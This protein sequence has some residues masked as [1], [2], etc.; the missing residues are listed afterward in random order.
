[1]F[2]TILETF[3]DDSRICAT[4]LAGRPVAAGI[5]YGFRQRLEIPWASADRRYHNLAPNMLLYS[6]ALEYAC[7]EGRKVF[8]FG[9]STPDTGTYRFKEQWGAEPVPLHWYYWLDNDRPLPELS[10]VNPKYRFAIEVWRRL[11]IVLTKAIG[12][13]IMRNLP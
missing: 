3:P 5:L 12:P 7:H 10:P 2:R 4:Y 11:P 6:T 1:V 9:R 13:V 8:D